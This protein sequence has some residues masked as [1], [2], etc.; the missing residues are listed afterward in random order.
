MGGKLNYKKKLKEKFF[1]FGMSLKVFTY[2]EESGEDLSGLT[3]GS[4]GSRYNKAGLRLDKALVAYN[5]LKDD[6]VTKKNDLPNE[7]KHILATAKQV[8]NTL[9]LRLTMKLFE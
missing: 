2:D 8:L 3:R 9:R 7:R 4:L 1:A 6:Q 5:T